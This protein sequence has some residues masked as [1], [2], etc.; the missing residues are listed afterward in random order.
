[1][2]HT[3]VYKTLILSSILAF[4]NI[5]AATQPHAAVI[6]REKQTQLTPDHVLQRLKEGNQRF[7]NG[8]MKNRDLMTQAHLSS[9]G[10][11]PLAV[12]LSC[13]DARTPPEIIFD[14]G[15]GDIFAIRIAGNIQ[16]DDILGSM[17]FGTQLSGSK[18][19]VVIGHTACGAIRGACQEAKLGHLTS[20]LQ[21]ISPAIRQAAKEKNTHDCTQAEFIDQ[22][23]K[24][25]V[26]LVMKQIQKRSPVI[27]KLVHEKKL[28]IVGGL[29]N[30]ATGE[31]TFFN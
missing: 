15:I 31:V 28:K 24:D 22:I 23:A 26:L 30:L 6:T 9:T 2:K 18:L 10:Q 5:A 3:L 19:I 27:A 17:E 4:S 12:I 7:M 21:K 13:M 14:Q 8:R 25:N 29:Q 1:M 20:L 16:N 11:H